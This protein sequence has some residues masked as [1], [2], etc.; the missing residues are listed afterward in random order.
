MNIGR[1]DRKVVVEKR[2]TNVDTFGQHIETWR[3]RFKAWGMKRDD[4]ANERVEAGQVVEVTRT[5]WTM[6]YDKRLKHTDRIVYGSEHYYVLGIVEL[7]RKEGMK[8]LT[9]KR[10]S[11][12]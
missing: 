9:E 3:E 10:S 11:P 7:G 5:T 1:M 6:R 4:F 8:V 12:R 2:D